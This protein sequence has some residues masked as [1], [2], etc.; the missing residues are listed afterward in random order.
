[1]SKVIRILSLAVLLAAFIGCRKTPVD[2]GEEPGQEPQEYERYVKGNRFK[3][4]R[5]VKSYF[6]GKGK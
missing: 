5:R 3:E 1:M 6:I 4:P 2:N